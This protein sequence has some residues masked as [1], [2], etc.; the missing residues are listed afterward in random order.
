MYHADAATYRN[1]Q[2]YGWKKQVLFVWAFTHRDAML[3]ERIYTQM[4]ATLRANTVL[5]IARCD[6][7]NWI[8]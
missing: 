5:L 3:I 2:N 1:V 4:P 8:W 6:G 7:V